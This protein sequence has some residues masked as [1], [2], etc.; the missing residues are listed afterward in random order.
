MRKYKIKHK[1]NRRTQREVFTVMMR[2][3][4]FWVKV[5]S[6]SDEDAEYAKDSAEEVLY[7]LEREE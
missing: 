5:K 7:Y 4:I 1:F 6:I 3:L 2:K